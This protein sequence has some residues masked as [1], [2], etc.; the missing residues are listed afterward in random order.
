MLSEPLGFNLSSMKTYYAT[1]K[2]CKEFDTA[3]ASLRP[4]AISIAETRRLLVMA[5]VGTF[6]TEKERQMLVKFEDKITKLQTKL[7]KRAQKAWYHSA[8][9]VQ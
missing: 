3:I 5:G 9:T 7:Y 1:A 2:D 6:G 8:G 4:L